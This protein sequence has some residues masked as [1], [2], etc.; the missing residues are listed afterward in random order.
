[1]LI[2]LLSSDDYPSLA[3]CMSAYAYN[4]R[5]SLVAFTLQ[6]TDGCL[7]I[8]QNVRCFFVAR[9]VFN[10]FN[11]SHVLSVQLCLVCMCLTPYEQV[12]AAGATLFPLQT[13]AQGQEMSSNPPPVICV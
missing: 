11:M 9:F 7:W 4:F 6:A 12:D 1:M 5:R 10:I 3:S 8:M 2:E 13:P